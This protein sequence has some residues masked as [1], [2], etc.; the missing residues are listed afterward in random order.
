[1]RPLAVM[2]N[3][4]VDL[5]MGPAA[6]WPQPGTEVMLD[7]DDL[8]PGGSAGNTALAWMGLG[9]PCRIAASVGDDLFGRWLADAFGPLAAD[10]V[11][12]PQATCLSVGLTHPDGER[13]FF[14]MRGH[15]PEMAWADLRPQLHG[16]EGGLLLLSG[17]FLTDRLAGDYPAVLGWAAARGIEVALDPGW[18]PGGW[19][20]AERGR[21]AVWAGGAQHLLINEAEALALTGAA[22]AEAALAPLLAMMPAGAAAVIKAGARGA[23]AGRGA[24]RAHAAAPAV[25][26]LDTIGAGDTFNAG[27]LAAVARGAG[28]ATALATGAALA[29]RAIS[30]NPRRYELPESLWG[31]A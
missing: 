22:R 7:N 20:A 29:S 3:V 12:Q 24:E 25:R 19:G 13:T 9:L 16:I 8:R 28:L 17:G 11:R 5:I 21:F 31:A 1:M 10:W 18:P 6:P 2:G 26:V 4:N 23:I 30:T 14:T 15:L 27:Y